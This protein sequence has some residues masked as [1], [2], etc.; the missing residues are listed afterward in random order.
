MI[1]WLLLR[2]RWPAVVLASLYLALTAEPQPG[3]IAAKGQKKT[4]FGSF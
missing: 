3:E 1:L 4:A 2:L